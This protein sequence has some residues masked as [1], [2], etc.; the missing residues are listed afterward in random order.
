MT[1]TKKT[2]LENTRGRFTT[3]K[4]KRAKGQTIPYCAKVRGVSESGIVRFLDVNTEVECRARL[5]NV[6]LA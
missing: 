6:E 5:E 3:L 1:N 2:K 4:V